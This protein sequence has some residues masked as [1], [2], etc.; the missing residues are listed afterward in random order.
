MRGY[1][2][3]MAIIQG[4]VLDILRA[5]KTIHQ[6]SILAQQQLISNL[7]QLQMF[8]GYL[9]VNLGL[10][11]SSRNESLRQMWVDGSGK[12]CLPQMWV[13]L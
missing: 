1:G 4:I 8:M 3:E 13:S 5:L 2:I 10:D 12:R 9:L 7:A 11:L 6:M